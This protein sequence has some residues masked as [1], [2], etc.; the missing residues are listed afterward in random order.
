MEK[1]LIERARDIV[2]N[3]PPC[4]VAPHLLRQVISDL[5]TALEAAQAA[6]L[7]NAAIAEALAALPILDTKSV[8]RLEVIDHRIAAVS[9]GRGHCVWEA[10]GLINVECQL[11]DG[12]RTLK[13]FLND[14]SPV[15]A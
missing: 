6:A 10:P 14:K 1:P 3:D 8:S 5:I 13:V 2:R 11:Q 9:I 12:G 4:M 7:N 15:A